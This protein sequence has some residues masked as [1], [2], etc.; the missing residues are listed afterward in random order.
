MPPNP[1]LIIPFCKNKAS[2]LGTTS[3]IRMDIDVNSIELVSV[4]IE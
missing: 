2:F 4:K 1:N 3:F